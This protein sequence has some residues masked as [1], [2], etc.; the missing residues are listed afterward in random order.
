M[1][2][3]ITYSVLNADMSA[4]HKELDGVFVKVK[5]AL[6]KEHPSYIG[7]K[8]VTG[9][10]WLD[11]FNPADRRVLLGRFALASSK[12][13]DAAFDHAHRAQKDWARRPWQERVRLINKAA[14][15]ISERRQE[16]AAI[17]VL[18]TGKNRLEALGD[19]EEAADLFRY[20]AQ[21]MENEKGF[22]KPLAK[23]SPNEDTRSVLKPWGVFVVVAPFNFPMALA[24]GMASAALLG[25]NTVILKPSEETPWTGNKLYEVLRD[26]G[27]PDGVFQLVHGG[28]ELGAALTTHAKADGVVFTGSK[29]VGMQLLRQAASGVYPKPCFV[30]MGGKNPA[31]ICASAD[32]D[33]AVTGCMRSAFGLSGQKCSAL[34]RAYVHESLHDEFLNRLILKTQTL[35]IGDPV[36]QETFIGPVI[37]AKSVERYAQAAAEAKRDGKVLFGGATLEKSPG[38]EHGHF[39][40]PTIVSVPR[41]HRLERE[42]LFLPFMIVAP[43]KT[44]DEAIARAND[45]DYGLTG[46]VFSADKAE[47]E[48]FMDEL[49]AGVLYSNRETGATTG[50][51]PGV[52]AFCGWKGSGASGKG[53]CGPYYVSQFMREQSQ[54]RMG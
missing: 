37:N 24:A 17:M 7:A 22:V 43:F 34:S 25:G 30:E 15:L 42:E 12:D 27:L 23:L 47:V 41:G 49:E 21:Q 31:I 44:L 3:R 36:L 6:G 48:R 38:L 51:W 54:T 16:L 50:A 33:K 26:A 32:L 46:G 52:Q 40:A 29:H 13:V 18:E 35:K 11:D 1:S 5:G 53:G 4:L 45:C 8:A 20:Y 2:F 9:S 39:V 14:D 28:R 10:A 19:V